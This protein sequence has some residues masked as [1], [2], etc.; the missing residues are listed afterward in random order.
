MCCAGSCC[1]HLL[2][3]QAWTFNNRAAI[4]IGVTEQNAAV[5]DH[6]K[7]KRLQQLLTRL[8]EKAGDNVA[9]TFEQ[10]CETCTPANNLHTCK[11]PAHLQRAWPAVMALAA[12]KQMC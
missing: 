9:V 10:V 12:A 2:C 3:C 1:I 7:L 11:H 6:I 8:V 4:V 5:N